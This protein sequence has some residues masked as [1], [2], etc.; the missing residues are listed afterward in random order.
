MTILIPGEILKCIQEP[1]WEISARTPPRQLFQE[2]RSAELS[3]HTCCP[4]FVVREADYAEY[5]SDAWPNFLGP[6]THACDGGI[7]VTVAV[8]VCATSASANCVSA[9]YTAL[10]SI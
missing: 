5:H 3:V 4:K 7:R 10:K 2:I 1:V 8:G 6:S 9:N